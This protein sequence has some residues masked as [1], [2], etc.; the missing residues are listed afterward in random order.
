MD[1]T[2]EYSGSRSSVLKYQ[3]YGSTI[4]VCQFHLESGRLFGRAWMSSKPL[5]KDPK[6]HHMDSA[7]SHVKGVG[8]HHIS[9]SGRFVCISV[10]RF[11]EIIK[12]GGQNICMHEAIFKPYDLHIKSKF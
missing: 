5:K 4:S 8:C 12:F 6:L 3:D 10:W 1:R 9:A 7:E 11:Q 2:N